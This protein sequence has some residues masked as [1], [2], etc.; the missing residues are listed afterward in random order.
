[1][2]VTINPTG[3]RTQNARWCIEGVTP[4]LASGATSTLAVA[5][6]KIAFK[7]VEGH[8]TPDDVTIT[9]AMITA[10]TYTATYTATQWIAAW[11]PP[12]CG[13]FFRGQVIVGG[14]N[15]SDDTK[16]QTIRWSE[17]GAFRF[18]NAGADP[19]KN[20]AGFIFLKKGPS[21]CALSILPMEDVVFIY[22]NQQVIRMKPVSQPA[23]TYGF[24]FDFAPVG[25][26]SPLAAA[27]N[28]RNEQIFIDKDG[29]LWIIKLGKYGRSEGYG[30][31]KLGYSHIFGPIQE[32]FSATT[33]VGLIAIVYN[34]D[35]DEYYIS[36]GERSFLYNSSGLTEI[37]VT[38]TSYINVKNLT[39]SDEL[40]AS[41]QTPK[42][43]CVTTLL[44]SE[45]VYLES[46]IVDFGLSG[47]KT[48]RQV[49]V[50][51]SF[52]VAQDVQVMIKWRMNRG[53]VFKETDWR[54]CSPNG[55]ATPVVSGTDFKVCVRISPVSG[56]LLEGCT[57]EWQLSDK[58]SVRGNYVSKASS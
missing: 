1:M 49:E 5:G 37:G 47:I 40:F 12:L 13:C 25:I 4:W 57:I 36:N 52:G 19:R 17:I 9:A 26:T 24:D 38:V 16:S 10:T 8:L 29:N 44:N 2:T 23:P 48:L 31:T 11:D 20:T 43:G 58:T 6:Q 51:G 14:Y 22:T 55:V 39:I 53:D 46:D 18:L 33:G 34:P 32:N 35:E 21:E 7:Y 28:G 3:I 45:Y 15:L 54:R 50:M 30:A 56:V 27:T 41:H 42:I